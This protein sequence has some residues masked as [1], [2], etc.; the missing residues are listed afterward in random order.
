MVF[1]AG[2]KL[3]ADALNAITRKAYIATASSTETVVT[4]TVA[5]LA[6]ATMSVTTVVANTQVRVTGIFDSE[7]SGATDIMIGTCMAN[8][9]AQ[10][11]EAHWQGD[12]RGTVM[13]EWLVTFAS[14]GTYTI[15]L[16]VQKINNT[17]TVV[18]YGSN[19]S[20]IVSEANGI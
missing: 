20:K 9:V 10:Q 12:A 2:Q 18:V 11:G 6:G 17:N 3:T 5:D 8:G 14:A 7:S 19:H 1:A 13:N 15:K 16:R 4:T